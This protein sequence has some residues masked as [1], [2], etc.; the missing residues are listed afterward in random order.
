MV[1]KFLVLKPADQLG[2]LLK[3]KLSKRLVLK[4]VAG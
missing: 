2:L 3:N 1:T 4:T